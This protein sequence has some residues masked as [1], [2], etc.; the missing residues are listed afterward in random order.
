MNSVTVPYVKLLE[1]CSVDVLVAMLNTADFLGKLNAGLAL[2][3]LAIDTSCAEEV[4]SVLRFPPHLC[5]FYHDGVLVR[6]R[7][8]FVLVVACW[9]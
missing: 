3:H 4:R 9:R 8:R 2:A 1:R 6:C 5:L 7:L